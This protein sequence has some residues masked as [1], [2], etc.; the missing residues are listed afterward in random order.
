MGEFRMPSLGANMEAGTLLLWKVAPG[1]R[2]TRGQVIAEVATDK[3]DIEVEVFEDGVVDRILVDPGADVPVGTPLAIIRSEGAPAAKPVEAKKAPSPPPT[4]AEARPREAAAPPAAREAERQR[5]VSPL[6]RKL[7]AEMGVDLSTLTGTGP[8]GAIQKED[9]ERAAAEKAA[10]PAPSDFHARMRRAIAASMARAN[11]EIPHYYLEAKIDMSRALAWL[12]ERNREAPIQERILPVVL[13]VK[14]V[15]RALKDVPELNGFWL[16]DRHQP[17][18]KIHVGFAVSLRGGG[19]VAPAI[20]DTDA[21]S[22]QELMVHI[23]DL[24][25]RAR[26]GRLR[27]SEMADA[28]ITV[29]NLGDLG[30]ETVYGV[31]N[32]P[33][34]ALVGFGRIAE[35]PWAENGLL[36]VRPVL[37]AT[38]SADHRATDG[39]RGAQLLDALRRH[40]QEPES[41]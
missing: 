33:Q 34:V 27:S 28:T 35:R 7:A 19:L 22:L 31:I 36:G 41:L 13:L 20:H 23:G 16:D 39:R 3:G 24:I 30:V 5:R 26:A 18:E 32:P 10:K 4:P 17:Q 29:T 40:L 6:A 11:R 2:V 25:Q 14:A 8:G 15:A 21:K 37:T 9:V 1:D 12:E 38:L